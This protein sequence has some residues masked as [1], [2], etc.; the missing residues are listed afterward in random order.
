M[1]IENKEFFLIMLRDAL[2]GSKQP[3]SAEFTAGSR[4][5][6]GG[7]KQML[8]SHELFSLLYPQIK[9]QQDIPE[10]T[11]GFLK[12]NYYA[13][14]VRCQNIWREFL[15]I[16]SAFTQEGIPLVPIKG[17]AFLEDLYVDN[18]VR[19]MTDID[20][21]IKEQDYQKAEQ[22]FFGLGYHK[23]SYSL[24][25]EYWRKKGYHVTFHYSERGK[26][27]PVELHWSL[28]YK[29][30]K[31]NLFPELW[32]R[33]REVD[34]ASRKITFLS[35]E[36]NFLSLALHNRRYG[37]TLSLKNVFD[38]ALILVKY[39]QAF[40]WGYVLRI[41][42][43]YRLCCSLFYLLEQVQF[44]AGLSAPRWVMR[45]LNIP[46]YKQALIRHFIERNT[47]LLGAGN[48]FLKSHFLLFDNL[49]EPVEY[50]IN[51]PQ[52]QFARF[53]GLSPYG[54]K[55]RILYTLRFFYIPFKAC[56]ILTAGKGRL[57][58]IGQ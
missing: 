31:K 13:S 32:E 52:E 33:V 55:T 47:F 28:D 4:V 43:K 16:S 30:K 14:L 37:N 40:D 34:F 5:D 26:K 21:L 15:R 25:E 2:L 8:V 27:P 46:L 23:E 44:A 22:L 6:W 29:R 42:K 35:P 20:L 10:K 51:I 19:P 50:I 48:L 56:S 49:W 17:V 57:N 3:K 1:K 58:T 45:E 7:F 12:D 54:E 38:A 53:F 24:K 9:G 39:S 36:D 41:S 11:R 18:P